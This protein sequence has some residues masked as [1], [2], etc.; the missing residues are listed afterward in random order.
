MRNQPET[1]PAPCVGKTQYVNLPKAAAVLAAV[2]ALAMPSHATAQT[3]IQGQFVSSLTSQ[4]N[5]TDY[6]TQAGGVLNTAGD[7]WNQIGAN[8][9]GNRFGNLSV[10]NPLKD[11][12]GNATAVNL[13]AYIVNATLKGIYAVSYG[14]PF[15]TFNGFGES[16]PNFSLMNNYAYSSASGPAQNVF[17]FTGLTP[18]QYNFYA[19]TSGDIDAD[20]RRLA[21]EVGGITQTSEAMVNVATTSTFVA[22][23]NYLLFSNL[24]VGLDGTLSG[25]WWNPAGAEIMANFN[26]FQLQA[27][28]EPHEYAMVACAG[29]VGF[30]LWRR[31]SQAASKA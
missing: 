28:P 4:G 7:T 20:G 10:S 31:R 17:S 26:G 15:S 3:V 5:Y 24:T 27:V 11:A 8:L 21:M 30:G 2:A 16:N 22:N 25:S 9:R 18:G 19:Y 23:R 29:M 12:Q 14:V 6:Q 1:G 13:T